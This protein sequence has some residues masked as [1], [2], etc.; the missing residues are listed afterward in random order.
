VSGI[1]LSL[2]LALQGIPVQ[3]GGTVTGVLRDS[4]GMPVA[5]VRMAAVT[6]GDVIENAAGGSMAGIAETDPQGRFTLENIPPGRYVIAA[7]RL[8]RQTYYPGTQALTDATVLTIT[9]GARI[10]DINFVLND[11]S[12]GRESNDPFSFYFGAVSFTTSSSSAVWATIPVAVRVDNGGKVP[13]TANGKEVSLTLSS[14]SD[15]FT[16][17]ID[18]RAVSIAGP[19]SGDFTVSVDGLPP[20]YKVKTITY[21]TTDI[22]NSTFAL[23]TANFSAQSLM[24]FVTNS[25]TG[26]VR[27]VMS[28]PAAAMPP[29]ALSITLDYVPPKPAGVRVSG[30][31]GITANK[32]TL[33][34]SGVAGVVFSDRS[35]EF[36][37]VPPG[38][39]LIA[40]MH[41]FTPQAAFVVVGD[42]DIDGI[43][44]KRTLAQPDNSV[45][46][47]VTPAGP[48]APG[49]VVP[50]P[51]ILGTAFD[52]RTGMPIVEGM[53]FVENDDF[54]RT[55]SLDSNG[56]FESFAL[57]P[58]NYD[59][60]LWQL[61]HVASKVK[62]AIEGKDVEIKLAIRPED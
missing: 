61:G 10:A 19:L 12:V 38:R 1:L 58:G 60:T 45:P 11:A 40:A 13:V 50:L 5:G 59:V 35:F 3:Q 29:S 28:A 47:T 57:F 43:E 37:G 8:D 4:K 15:Q 18:A 2:I 25:T 46:Q 41:P 24:T 17:P 30:T 33:Y 6:R 23:T 21:G 62:V 34:I 44:L 27:Y 39:H 54:R 52:E 49:T 36:H 32:P 48:Y 9:R 55:F 22:T 14:K 20:P 16:Y 51:R 7:G 26:V 31:V 56:R 53:V 42:R